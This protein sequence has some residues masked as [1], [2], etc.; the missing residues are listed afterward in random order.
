MSSSRHVCGTIESQDSDY[1]DIADVGGMT[2][3]DTRKNTIEPFG[4]IEKIRGGGFRGVCYWYDFDCERYR[5][6]CEH[7]H[8]QSP[9]SVH[10]L[11]GKTQ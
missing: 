3:I 9:P 6:T 10:E 4:V 7:V 2:T 8:N 5:V 1:S 11:P